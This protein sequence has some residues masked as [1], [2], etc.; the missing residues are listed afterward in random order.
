MEEG[1]PAIWP[2]RGIF[3]KWNKVVESLLFNECL[4]QG[5]REVLQNNQKQRVKDRFPTANEYFRHE[6]SKPHDTQHHRRIDPEQRL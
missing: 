6:R 3:P 4:K 5:F 2:P 1:G